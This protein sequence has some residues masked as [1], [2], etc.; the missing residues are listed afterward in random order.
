ML[1]GKAEGGFYNEV[2]SINTLSFK[3]SKEIAFISKPSHAY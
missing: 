3:F 2:S 1:I